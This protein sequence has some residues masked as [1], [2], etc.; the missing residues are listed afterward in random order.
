LSR[1]K[2]ELFIDLARENNSLKNSKIDQ[3]KQKYLELDGEYIVVDLSHRDESRSEVN[4]SDEKNPKNR[5]QCN[6]RNNKLS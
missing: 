5:F 6:T 1:L 4:Q 3:K 2:S